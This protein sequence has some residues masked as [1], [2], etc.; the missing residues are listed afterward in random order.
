MMHVEAQYVRP[1][2]PSRNGERLASLE[3]AFDRSFKVK[4]S[5]AFTVVGFGI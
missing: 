1:S 4:E 2:F 3:D 5:N